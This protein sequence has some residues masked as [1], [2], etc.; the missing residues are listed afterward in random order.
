[1]NSCIK[2][3]YGIDG[4]RAG[5][6][7]AK[8]P[9]GFDE[10]IIDVVSDLRPIFARAKIDSV[11]AI[12][13]PIGLAQNEPRACDRAARQLLGWPRASS[14]FS[15]PAREA[16]CAGSF[17]EALR[18]NREILRIGISKQAFH[19]MPKIREVDELMSPQMQ[20]Y[21]REVHPEVTFVQLNRGPLSYSKK[22][23]RGR[24]E[25]IRLLLT[26]GL[27]ISEPSLAQQ[28]A[29]LG[30]R[31]LLVDDVIDALACLITAS[32][33]G[34]GESHCL[35]RIGQKDGK[36]LAMEIVCPAVGTFFADKLAKP[37]CC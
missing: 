29:R 1:V 6:V 5:W 37:E 27:D 28:R 33:I 15:P 23:V 20:R 8:A 9:C 13:I 12:D 10:V 21:V 31:R 3:L 26:A 32:A 16:L 18:M 11:I 36:D 4:C 17:T 19:I 14:V 30:T 2:W 24:A 22:D 25:R 35:G 34:R 7:V